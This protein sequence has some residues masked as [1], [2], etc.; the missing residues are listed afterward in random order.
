MI[1]INFRTMEA[2]EQPIVRELIKALY[3]EDQ[4]EKS[5]ITEENIDN[6]F[7]QFHCDPCH[8]GIDVIELNS[9]IVGYAILWNSWS[10]EYGGSILN[11]D[12][13]YIVPEFRNKGL[14]TSYITYLKKQSNSFVGLSLEIL[15]SN[16]RALKLYKCIGFTGTGRNYLINL[17]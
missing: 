14:A 13:L 16:A 17:L 12:E 9:Q 5:V 1:A 7:R 6:T 15:P 8:L 11:I 3:H 4:N 2:G 10:N